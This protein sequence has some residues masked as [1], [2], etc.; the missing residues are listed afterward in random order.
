MV[1]SCDLIK[2]VGIFYKLLYYLHYCL[3]KFLIIGYTTSLHTQ[4]TKMKII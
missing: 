4:I 2:I 1:F 3:D